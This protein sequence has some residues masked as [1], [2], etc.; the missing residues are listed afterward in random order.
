MLLPN[1]YLRV[2]LYENNKEH[3]EYVHRLVAKTFIPN[4]ENKPQ[5]NHINGIKTDNRVEN[6]E[7]ATISENSIHSAEIL[8]NKNGLFGLKPIRCVETGEEFRSIA[9]AA[10]HI[11]CS[12]RS[13][14]YHISKHGEYMGLHWLYI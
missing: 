10:K 11:G 14:S 5:V 8:G 1:G 6:L 9:A 2:N 3:G 13:M 12:R 7:W 4:P